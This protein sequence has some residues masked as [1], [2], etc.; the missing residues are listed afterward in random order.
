[1][2][3]N[4]EIES[5]TIAKLNDEF[6]KTECFRFTE[7]I[8]RLDSS[9]IGRL[10]DAI[11]LF[12]FDEADDQHDFGAFEIDGLQFIWKI[13][14]FDNDYKLNSQEPKGL[15]VRVLAVRLAEENTAWDN[16]D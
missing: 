9:W 6:R 11:R 13:H 3:K 12:K 2:G 10:D 1:M 14:Y 16:K 5:M 7:G 4:L 8:C 15:A